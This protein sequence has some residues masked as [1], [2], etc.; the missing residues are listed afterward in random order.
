MTPKSPTRKFTIHMS[1]DQIKTFKRVCELVDMFPAIDGESVCMTR[2]WWHIFLQQFGKRHAQNEEYE[3]YV[4]IFEALANT[5]QEGDPDLL[6]V[7]GRSEQLESFYCNQVV[8]GD[9]QCLAQCDDCW[10][11]QR[12]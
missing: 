1:C 6:S 7:V 3:L 12:K 5:N 4:F 2:A 11:W 9:V 8:A 10:R